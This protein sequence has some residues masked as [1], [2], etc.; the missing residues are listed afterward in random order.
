[1]WVQVGRASGQRVVFDESGQALD[2]LAAL[3]A[4][5]LG[6]GQGEEEACTR[7]VPLV[8][9]KRYLFPCILQGCAHACQWQDT[10][11]HAC[12]AGDCI[13][14]SGTCLPY[15]LECC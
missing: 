11:T 8:S 5:G 7:Y 13:A 4:E 1:M 2:P 9:E 14:S 10:S 3:A 12:H 6:E 15:L